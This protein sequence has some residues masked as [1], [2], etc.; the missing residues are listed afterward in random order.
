MRGLQSGVARGLLVINKYG[1]GWLVFVGQSTSFRNRLYLHK[2][3]RDCTVPNTYPTH[4][5]F[6]DQTPHLRYRNRDKQIKYGHKN[7]RTNV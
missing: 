5:K 2:S 3:T 1:I 6:H 4:A 7:S